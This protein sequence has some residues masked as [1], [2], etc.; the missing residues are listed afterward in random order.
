MINIHL[1]IYLFLSIE[2]LAAKVA[3][4]VGKFIPRLLAGW[5][6]GRS[7]YCYPIVSC[8]KK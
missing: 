5:P 1:L 3:Q 8:C 2:F 4:L 6:D 7:I